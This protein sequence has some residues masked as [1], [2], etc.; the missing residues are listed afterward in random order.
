VLAT[1]EMIY[2]RIEDTPERALTLVGRCDEVYGLGGPQVRRLSNQFFFEK[3]LVT[4]DDTVQIAGAVLQEPWS[5]LFAEDFQ[6]EMISNAT[7]PRP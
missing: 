4:D 3:L 6:A 5:T 1:A 7:K 2:E